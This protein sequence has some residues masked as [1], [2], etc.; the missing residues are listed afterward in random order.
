MAISIDALL[1]M[2]IFIAMIAFIS[3]EPASNLPLTQPKIATSQLVDDA[4]AAMDN[5]GFIME[6]IDGAHWDSIET[7]LDALLPDNIAYRVEMARYEAPLYLPDIQ[8][9][10][11][12]HQDF[13]TCFPYDANIYGLGAPVPEDKDVFH[14]R[15]IFI[16]KEP[17]DCGLVEEAKQKQKWPEAFFAGDHAPEA[18]DVNITIG[19]SCPAIRN[20]C[21]TTD[22]T[23][24]CCYTYYDADSNPPV[25]VEYKWYRYNEETSLWDPTAETG[26]TYALAET[27][28]TNRFKCAVKVSDGENPEDWG[29][30]TN[31]PLAIVGGPCFMF[32]ASATG[33][34]LEC[35][36]TT[37]IDFTISA[38]AGGRQDPV[39][40]MLS[41]DRSGS[42]SWIGQYDASGTE[43]SV[44]FD[45]GASDAFIG[46]DMYVYKMDVNTQSGSLAYTGSRAA[47]DDAIDLGADNTYVYVADSDSGIS[48]IRKSDVAKIRTIGQ[49]GDA[50]EITSARG[51]FVEGDYIY[52]SAA[53]TVVPVPVYD[54]G[55]TNSQT[56]YRYIG[57]SATYSWAVQSFIPSASVVDGVRLEL[58]RR[59][60]NSSRSVTAHLRS[61]LTGA[62]LPNGTVTVQGND[63]C[64]RCYAWQNFDFPDSVSVTPGNTYYVVLTAT[65]SAS[66]SDYFRWSSRRSSWNDPYA[67]G[68]MH[69][70]ASP[71][72]SGSCN[73][74]D[75]E[76]ARFRTYSYPGDTLAGGLVIIDKSDASV[77]NWHVRSNL[78]DT[79]SGLI[80][81]PEGLFVSGDYAYVTDKQ[82]GD[83]TVGLWI[84]DISD[85]D[86]PALEGF[87]ATTNA[88]AVV[89][90]GNYAYVADEDGGLRVVDISNKSSPSILTTLFAGETVKD[91]AL[92]DTNIYVL[93]DTGSGATADG[94]HVLSIS[95]PASPS[96]IVTFDSPYNFYKLDAGADYVFAAMSYGLITIDRLFGPKINFARNSAKEFVNYEDWQSPDDRLGVASYGN[97]SSALN[98]QLVDATPAN[99]LAITTAINGIMSQGGTPMHLG[100]ETAIDELLGPRGRADAI[101]FIILLADGQSDSGTQVAI[102]DQVDRAKSNQIYIFTIGIGGD[103]DDTQMQNI[104]TNAYCPNPAEDECG[105]YHHISDPQALSDVYK[106]ISERIA[107]LSGRMP[108][109]ST[110]DVSMEFGKF[111]DGIVVTD[112]GPDGTWDADSN[113]L[114]FDGL[115]VR[116]GWS[117]SFKATI[118]CNYVGCG[119]DF[120]EGSV[121]DFP[122]AGTV[123]S[124]SIDGFEQD[125]VEWPEKFSVNSTL[126]YSD[127]GIDFTGGK[128][129][130]VNDA[131]VDY[132]LSNIGYNSIDL[133]PMVPTVNFYQSDSPITACQ[134]PLNEVGSASLTKV[135][136]AAFGND[137]GPDT[138]VDAESSLNGSGYICI[139]LNKNQ[140]VAECAENNQVKINCDIPETYLYTMDYWA[141]EK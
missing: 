106:I 69:Y 83:G 131:K 12:S 82:G 38:E 128:F 46:T 125:P 124:F 44:V 113:T 58:Y 28:D 20:P 127:L 50:R 14:G 77:S 92:Y 42:M 7:K 8:C 116:F 78:Y 73:Y 49:P 140:A 45:S 103:V 79:G 111:G 132:R 15:K 19:G 68:R 29:Q 60:N 23:M 100:L 67:N 136:D 115:D 40:I 122:P 119:D 135:L 141:W 110:T 4:I 24:R 118:P 91:I 109:K 5:T 96:T 134:E 27:N 2:V 61:S 64:Y 112:Y 31:S 80:D 9:R 70:C 93:A 137:A 98:S 139:W 62:D 123:I 3:S 133:S 48:V 97:G 6:S 138:I 85:K 99:K 30:D 21:P 16:K 121:V 33:L 107:E 86:S 10:D 59:A 89:V 22:E 114:G 39:D 47:I 76:D 34:P 108:D 101:Q 54:A 1:A 75:Y 126:Y 17:G 51:V 129:Y 18:R 13:E 84:V 65:G 88:Q 41:M 71:S 102:N 120:T 25:G 26:P 87:V 52:A 117:G 94:L 43:R 36:E 95:N 37:T 72:G 53:G 105:S 104:A 11:P 57:Y 63:L 81:E 130:G 66:T 90:S 32:E 55:M 74:Y 56:D 35:G